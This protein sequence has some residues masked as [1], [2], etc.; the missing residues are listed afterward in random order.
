[1]SSPINR[2]RDPFCARDHLIQRQNLRRK[3]PT[4]AE[5]EQLTRQPRRAVGRLDDLVGI[6][7]A[8][9]VVLERVH[10]EL[11]I[12]ADRREEVVEVVG[13]ASG[14]SADRFHLLGL[15]ELIFA[16]AEHFLALLALGD[17]AHDRGEVGRAARLP[18][19]H[20]QLDRKPDAVLPDTGDFNRPAELRTG[21]VR[22][23]R[24][25]RGEAR[26]PIGFRDEPGQRL[27][28]RLVFGVTEDRP[29]APA[30]ERDRAVLDRSK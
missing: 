3:D 22:A 16:L 10:H 14:Q 11:A 9:I 8:W 5:R 30:P 15:P 17:I 27:A 20:G 26:V 28:D 6:E 23:G 21:L 13:H 2:R 25:Q 4:A 1:M 19:R 7:P 24:R 18:R 29:R 12:A